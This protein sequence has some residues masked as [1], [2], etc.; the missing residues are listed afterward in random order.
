[1]PWGRYKGEELGVIKLADLD[2]LNWI[3]NNVDSNHDVYEK[4]TDVLENHERIG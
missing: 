2:Y 4:V 3:K 1:M